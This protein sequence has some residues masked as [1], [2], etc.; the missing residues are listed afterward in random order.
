M[1]HTFDINNTLFTTDYSGTV[2]FYIFSQIP[3]RGD[4]VL[5]EGVGVG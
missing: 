5:S 2:I 1:K 4:A 3:Q